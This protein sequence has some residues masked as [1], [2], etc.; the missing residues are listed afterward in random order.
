LRRKNRVKN[1]ENSLDL[2]PMMDIVFIMLIFFIVTTSFV[3]ETG[4]DINRPNAETAERDER[5]N[6]LV[7]ITANNEIW[8][9]KRRVD[10][11]A[12]RA[13]IERL[14]IEY[15]EGSVIIQADKE[16]RSGLL[17]EAMDQI[18]LAG[19]QNISIAA[20]NDS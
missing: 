1:E 6:I 19:V 11:K 10:L 5:G 9:D 7:A 20:K 2:T 16:S 18:R 4:V 12:V 8:I 15:P 14:K 13:N 17:V 3:K